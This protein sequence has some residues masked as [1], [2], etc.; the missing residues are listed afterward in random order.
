MVDVWSR[1]AK[2]DVSVPI[3]REYR[4]QF[5][6]QAISSE[7]HLLKPPIEILLK[8]YFGDMS[9]IFSFFVKGQCKKGPKN[10]FAFAA[11]SGKAFRWWLAEENDE[12][13]FA[14]I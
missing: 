10:I 11:E 13:G 3:P 5:L 7:M 4:L 9:W 8:L 1:F 2:T 6:C 12:L 14:R